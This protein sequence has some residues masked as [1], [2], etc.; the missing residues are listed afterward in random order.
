M[1]DDAL[2][3]HLADTA[4]WMATIRAVE[5]RRPDAVFRDELAAHLSGDQAMRIQR[6]IPDAVLVSWAVVMRTS[7]IDRL[8]GSALRE[9]IDTVVNLGAGLDARPYRLRLPADLRW[10]EVD[11]PQ[12]VA[13]KESRLRGRRPNCVLERIGMDLRE[14]SK[15]NGLFASLGVES[16][17]TLL[18]TEGLIP[19]LSVE[20]AAALAHDARAIPAIRYWIQDFDDAGERR[21]LC[22]T[23]DGALKAAPRQFHVK[24]WFKFFLNAGWSPRERITSAEEAARVGRPLPLTFPRG[25]LMRILPASMGRK[26]L[27]R[28]GAVLMEPWDPRKPGASTQSR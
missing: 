28:S 1:A 2:I 4:L 17:R 14:R 27:S 18:I 7:A 11:F 9:R 22:G 8:I 13:H 20:E 19:Y 15:R 16:E 3:A 12:L 6:S 21:S 10:I 23:W 26:I 24:D 25:M 5:S